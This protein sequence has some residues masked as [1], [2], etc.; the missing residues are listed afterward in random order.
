MSA[1]KT[2]IL[3]GFLTALLLLAGQAIGGQGG[4]I[5]AFVFALVM[6]V[7]SYWFSDKLVLRMYRATEVGSDHPLYAITSRL[8]RRAGLPMPK[9]YVIPN[10]S[11]NAFA[12]G[13]NPQHAAVAATEGILRLLPEAELEGVIAHELAHVRHRDI[14]ISSVAA[15]I[16]AAIMML[17]HMAQWAAIFGGGSRDRDGGNPIALLGMAL[18]APLAAGLIQAAISRQREFA[19]DR[20]GAE[21]AGSPVGLA[22]ALRHIEAAARQV[23]LDANPATAHMFI[24]KPF[25]GRGLASLFSTHP[26]TEERVAALMALRGRV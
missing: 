11:P 8:A 1:F 26:P 6:N 12:T 4:L 20:G 7:G 21:I 22:S 9:V 10:A 16:A 18:L 24:M 17:A 25:S 15:T 3:L 19:A 2:A 14:L 23:P 13:R 5:V